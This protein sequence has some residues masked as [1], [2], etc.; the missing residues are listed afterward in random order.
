[1]LEDDAFG[2]EI[3]EM[4]SVN[5]ACQSLLDNS[6]E[7]VQRRVVAEFVDASRHFAAERSMVCT[8]PGEPLVGDRQSARDLLDVVI[9]PGTFAG[10]G[11]RQ[12]AE[13][14]GV[15]A[16]WETW[17]RSHRRSRWPSTP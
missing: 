17:L 1:M 7:G 13:H 8:P 2:Q 5:E 16:G 12:P 10:D 15:A 6:E 14:H 11:P 9:R 4:P 3:E